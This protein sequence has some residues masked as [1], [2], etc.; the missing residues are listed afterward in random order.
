MADDSSMPAE[1]PSTINKTYIEQASYWLTYFPYVTLACRYCLTSSYSLRLRG[2][3][4][5]F[6]LAQIINLFVIFVKT[7]YVPMLVSLPVGAV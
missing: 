5:L 7:Q 3:L 6:D 2:F 4:V 1:L